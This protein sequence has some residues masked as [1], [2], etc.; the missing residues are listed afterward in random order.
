MNL[1]ANRDDEYVAKLALDIKMREY[2]I[3]E[4]QFKCI[5]YQ[6]SELVETVNESSAAAI[7]ASLE[8][9]GEDN[10]VERL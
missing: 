2:K 7:S 6:V 1:S 4:A 3:T 8:N 9:N 5:M 10:S